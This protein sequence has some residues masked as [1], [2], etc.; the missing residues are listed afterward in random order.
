MTIDFQQTPFQ[1]MINYLKAIVK[2]RLHEMSEQEFKRINQYIENRF[3]E[4]FNACWVR[5]QLETVIF[6]FVKQVES[7]EEWRRFLEDLED[8]T[9]KLP[10]TNPVQIITRQQNSLANEPQ[11]FTYEFNLE[12]SIET[13]CMEGRFRYRETCQTSYPLKKGDVY[14]FN[15]EELEVGSILHGDGTIVTVTARFKKPC[16]LDDIKSYLDHSEF[17]LVSY[18]SKKVEDI[19]ATTQGYFRTLEENIDNLYISTESINTMLYLIQ[20]PE[21]HPIELDRFDENAMLEYIQMVEGASKAW[22]TEKSARYSE[23]NE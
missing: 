14:V 17:Y 19:D 7:W 22:S 3:A 15:Q 20:H 11:V 13:P 10:V 5:F 8:A 6:P 12:L 9:R 23:E 21:K 1:Q 18:K 2:N 4:G 16:F